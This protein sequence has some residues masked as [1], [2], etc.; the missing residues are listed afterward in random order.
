MRLKCLHT[1][2]HQSENSGFD[3]KSLSSSVWICRAGA[4]SFES[5]LVSMYMPDSIANVSR[6]LVPSFG[7]GFP[8]NALEAHQTS[9]C[10]I[11]LGSIKSFSIS[12]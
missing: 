11:L 6:L 7:R 1:L 5:L 8:S 10:R 2:L 9:N 3:A 12:L 4:V